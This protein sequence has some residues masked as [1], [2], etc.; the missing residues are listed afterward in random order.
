[1]KTKKRKSEPARRRTPE[2]T[3]IVCRI[4]SDKAAFVR[5]AK[6]AGELLVVD[7]GG[8]G[9]GRGAYVCRTA[10]CLTDGTVERRLEHS[11]RARLGDDDRAVLID[12]IRAVGLADVSVA[13]E[14][15]GPR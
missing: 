7:E 11:L 13:D 4:K 10:V 5:I 14:S 6:H 12:W 8:K 3:C 9:A 2:R 15:A 1:M